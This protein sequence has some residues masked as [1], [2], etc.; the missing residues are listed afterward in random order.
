MN[1][2]IEFLKKAHSVLNYIHF[3][4]GYPGKFV[5]LARR[6]GNDWFIAGINSNTP[7]KVTINT[8]FLKPGQYRINHKSVGPDKI[9][10]PNKDILLDTTKPFKIKM[11][12]NGGICA[13]IADSA[14]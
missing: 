13:K 10:L 12:V 8:D 4:D 5:I 11:A 7:H 2:G 9:I 3:I 14:K 1:P 6:K